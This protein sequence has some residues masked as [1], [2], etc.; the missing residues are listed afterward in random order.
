MKGD[1][2]NIRFGTTSFAF[3]QS[4]AASPLRSPKKKSRLDPEAVNAGMV[5]RWKLALQKM[6]DEY[7]DEGD[8]AAFSEVACEPTRALAKRAETNRAQSVSDQDLPA[9]PPVPDPMLE[10][11]GELVLARTKRSMLYWPAR[12]EAFVAAQKQKPKYEVVFLDRTRMVI[13]RDWFFTSE[14]G[15]FATCKVS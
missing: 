10:I 4:Q 2:G 9:I 12:L 7:E 8:D 11:P 13:P 14:E 15:E 5:G 6:L 1:H 3:S